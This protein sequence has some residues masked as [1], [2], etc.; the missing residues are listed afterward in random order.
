MPTNS[1]SFTLRPG[2]TASYWHV[3]GTDKE[4]EINPSANVSAN[5]TLSRKFMIMAN[6]AY[7]R[8]TPSASQS[9]NV[10][11]RQNELEW[12]RGNSGLKS[13]T[14]WWP[15]I[16]FV[17]MPTQNIRVFPSVSYIRHNNEFITTYE[18][19]PADMGGII[20][21]YAN[22]SPTESYSWDL[23]VAGD[24]LDNKQLSVWLQ[25]NWHYTRTKGVYADHMSYLRMRGG[26]SYTLKNCR[27]DVVYGGKE[28]VFNNGGMERIY[29]PDD[30]NFGFTYGTGDI[31]LRVGYTETFRKHSVSV[32][33]LQSDVFGSVRHSF[34]PG[35]SVNITLTYT[36]G[37][38]KKIDRNIN[39]Q[40]PTTVQSG[41][42]G[43]E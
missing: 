33:K 6:L 16:D 19:A 12:L 38:G 4:T 9:G 32:H 26:I 31:Y 28:K 13:T 29:T 39:I 42:L 21:T 43:S 3:E 10:L 5:W 24:F 34:S 23:H 1:L 40:G 36:F 17:W 2:I 30:W 22:A 8:H 11:L 35:R 27:F 18:A 15:M 25:P 37:Y 20:R 7:F 41:V 14:V